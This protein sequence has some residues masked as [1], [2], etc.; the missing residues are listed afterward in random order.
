[1]DQN[2][3]LFDLTDKQQMMDAVKFE[4]PLKEHLLFLILDDINKTDL[5]V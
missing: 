1:M 4:K 3:S 2:G 5:T